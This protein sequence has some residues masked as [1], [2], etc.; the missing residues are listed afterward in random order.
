[1]NSFTR[2]IKRLRPFFFL[3]AIWLVL[4]PF[5][6]RS[7]SDSPKANRNNRHFK[8]DDGNSNGFIKT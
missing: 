1:M 7:V 4:L 3:E 2:F 6:F 5:C 8:I